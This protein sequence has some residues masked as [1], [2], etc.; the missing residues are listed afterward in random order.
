MVMLQLPPEY[1]TDILHEVKPVSI[2]SVDS[3]RDAYQTMPGTETYTL[4]GFETRFE[5]PFEAGDEF[6]IAEATWV[7]TSTWTAVGWNEPLKE[8]RYR[9]HHFKAVALGRPNVELLRHYVEGA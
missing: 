5:E 8:T 7:I 2:P 1:I 4:E 3:F 9:R 6:V